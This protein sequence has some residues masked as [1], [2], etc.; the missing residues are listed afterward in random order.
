MVKRKGDSSKGNDGRKGGPG[1]LALLPLTLAGAW[2]G[3]SRFFINHRMPLPDAV[4]A[5]RNPFLSQAAGWLSYYVDKG[6]DST[7]ATTE[8]EGARTRPLVLIHSI[9]AAASA[10]E[11]APLFRHYRTSRPVY[12]L[13]LP[14][15]GFSNRLRRAYSPQLFADAIVEMLETQVGE[16][17]DVIALSLG[18]EFVARAAASQPSLFRSLVLISPSGFNRFDTGRA[19]Q[20]AG[21]RGWADRVHAVLS[22]PLWGRALFDLVSSRRSI[23][24]FLGQSFVGKPTPGFVDY[25]YASSHQPGAENAP[26]HFLSGR[27][28]TPNAA[29]ELYTRVQAP[30]LVIYDQDAYVSFDG[31]PTF[32]EQHP[33]WRAVR[34]V[35]SQGLPQFE[36]LGELAAELDAFW[37][38]HPG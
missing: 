30:S 14:G 37:E 9:N 19:S 32:L 28:F 25:A 5:E 21:M 29:A 3:Y 11:M 18:C 13:D 20:R 24:Y 4:L 33:N 36:R 31:L 22:F 15:Y 17:A 12:A 10:Y 1:G 16:P 6:P 26:L 2:I 7:S 27:L 23:E 38:S 35:P 8:E 34:F